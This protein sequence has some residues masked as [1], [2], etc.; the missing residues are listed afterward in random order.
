M[1]SQQLPTLLGFVEGNAMVSK[2]KVI[3]SFCPTS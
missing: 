1:T 3:I 2:N